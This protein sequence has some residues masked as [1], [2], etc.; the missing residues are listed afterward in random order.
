MVELVLVDIE[1]NW[2]K[3]KVMWV[4][5]LH[6]LYIASRIIHATWYKPKPY[7]LKM[8]KQYIN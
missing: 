7:L 6:S 5:I 3:Q 4:I 2:Q 8:I 1:Y